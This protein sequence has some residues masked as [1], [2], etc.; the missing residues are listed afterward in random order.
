[1]GRGKRAVEIP[2]DV[3]LASERG[4]DLLNDRLRRLEQ[5]LSGTA[6]SSGGGGTGGS[7]SG[8]GGSS[9]SGSGSDSGSGGGGSVPQSAQVTG[10]AVTVEESPDSPSLTYRF[11]FNW[12]HP[13]LDK[14][15]DKL[16]IAYRETD[17]SFESPGEWQQWGYRA[18]PG[19][20]PTWLPKPPAAKYYQFRGAAVAKSGAF[21]ESDAPIVNVTVPAADAAGGGGPSY[22]AAPG[23]TGFTVSGPN[24]YTISDGERWSWTANWTNP[25]SADYSGAHITVQRG[26]NSGISFVPMP[27]AGEGEERFVGDFPKPAA[28]AAASDWGL[29]ESASAYKTYRFRCY[30]FNPLGALNAAA[31]QVYDLTDVAKALGAAGTEY[32]PVILFDAPNTSIEEDYSADGID[33]FRVKAKWSI[34]AGYNYGGVL[35]YLATN[36]ASMATWTPLGFFGPAT[37]Q[38]VSPWF[39]KQ[40]AATNYYI[41]A[42]STDKMLRS[43]T[44]VS[45]VTPVSGPHAVTPSAGSIKAARVSGAFVVQGDGE[46]FTGITVNEPNGLGGFPMVGWIGSAYGDTT[47]LSSASALGATSIFVTNDNIFVAGDWVQVVDAGDPTKRITFRIASID[48]PTNR[49][50]VDKTSTGLSAL[51]KAFVINSPVKLLYQGAWFANAWFGGAG[52]RNSPAFIDNNGNFTMDNSAD[53]TRK[54]TLKLVGAASGVTTTIDGSFDSISEGYPGLNVFKSAEDSR[55]SILHNRVYGTRGDPSGTDFASVTMVHGPK[56][57]PGTSSNYAGLLLRTRLGDMGGEISLAADRWST[58]GGVPQISIRRIDHANSA[59]TRILS[60]NCEDGALLQ[61]GSSVLWRINGSGEAFLPGGV[62][63]GS[64]SGTVVI[65]SNAKVLGQRVKLRHFDNTYNDAAVKA[66]LNAGE[67]ATRYNPSAQT[68]LVVKFDDGSGNAFEFNATKAL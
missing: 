42:Q 55:M 13:P 34:P 30:P 62:K 58:A 41:V 53:T 54:A 43:N 28:T 27:G 24:K 44:Y 11:V 8:S 21:R 35:L 57:A 18:E 22:G 51:N 16:L 59:L 6:S 3:D 26:A 45:G 61:Q 48:Y 66:A 32:A 7:G 64:G 40:T 36:P 10:W 31:V 4:R 50:D 23:V 39:S 14:E 49:L 37:T 9:G 38:M 20:D 67:I 68:T 52:P 56:T 47:T 2:R 63:A 5:R 15:F 60:L 19:P 17:S 33:S 29:P 1:M 46:S 65:D 12:T 25:V